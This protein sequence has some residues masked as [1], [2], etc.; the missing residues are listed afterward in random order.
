MAMAQTL[1]QEIVENIL[2]TAMRLFAVKGVRVTSMADLAKEVGISTGNVYRYFPDK[3]ALFYAVIPSEFVHKT[4]ALLKRKMLAA[5]TTD[6]DQT[7]QMVSA[8]FLEYCIANRER[9]VILLSQAEGTKYSSIRR[10]FLNRLLDFVEEY[11]R[12]ALPG[13]VLT[14]NETLCLRRVYEA[15]MDHFLAI[16]RE[17]VDP[18]V[19]HEQFSAY[20]CYHL[21]GMKA[22]LTN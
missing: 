12:Q 6:H 21:A 20:S 22:I 14:Q 1:K 13:R 11:C 5:G 9:I 15:C 10:N 2:Q 4:E 3:E 8:K 7:H 17:N 18:T 19:I 16:L